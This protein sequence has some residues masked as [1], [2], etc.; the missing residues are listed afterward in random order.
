VVNPFV[1]TN[2]RKE[3]TTVTPADIIYQR[4]CQVIERAAVVGVAR[5][6][7][8]AGVSRTSYY[9]WVGKAS[10]YG[11]SALLPKERRRPVLRT[12]I[13]AHEEEVILAEAISRPTLGARRLLE[14]LQ[15]RS[16]RRSC[17]GV[18]KALRRHHLGHRR[19]RVAALAVLTAADTGLVAP[20]AIEPFGFCL[21]AHRAGDLVGLD[22]FYVGKLKGIG[23][24]YQL[25]AVDTTTRWAICSLMVG[26]VSAEAMG[27]FAR[28]VATEISDLGAVLSGVLT[29]NGPEFRGAAFARTLAELEVHHHRI[30][31][32][33]PNHNAVVERFHGTVLQECYRPGFH[34][35]RYDRLVDLDALLQDWVG[36]YNHRRRNRGDY[37]RGRT[38][39]EV[40]EG[41]R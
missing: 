23:P 16:I 1:G 37:M 40:L 11:L 8:E 41:V 39:L 15:D 34:R 35:R 9:R 29:D 10:R 26:H 32:R 27:A 19:E 21:W 22:A 20:R 36:R 17:S 3:T 5:A 30:P 38:P 24:I 13:P 4:R 25:T 28:H 6:C 33:S 7:R 2:H 12:Q 18:Q 14:H 31:P